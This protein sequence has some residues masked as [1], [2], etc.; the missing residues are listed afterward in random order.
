MPLFQYKAF[1]ASGG[2]AEGQIEAG[3]RQEAFRQMEEKG[4]K[5]ISLSEKAAPKGGVAPKSA[6]PDAGAQAGAAP[7]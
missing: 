4:L 3:G 5:P 6:A 7:G 2:I 1:Q